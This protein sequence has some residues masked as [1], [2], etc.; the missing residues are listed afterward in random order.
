MISDDIIHSWFLSD[1]INICTTCQF[2]DSLSYSTILNSLRFEVLVLKMFILVF[3]HLPWR[4]GRHAPLKHWQLATRVLGV[5]TQKTTI[6]IDIEPSSGISSCSSPNCRE[7]WDFFSF[8]YLIT[9]LCHYF[10]LF[11]K[12]Y[13]IRT[14]T[15]TNFHV[16]LN[17]SISGYCLLQTF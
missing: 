7:K 5:T 17:K 10:I 9:L 15:R 3:W 14:V 12:R 11:V 8:R 6:N 4:R 2:S 16:S 1:G 13:L